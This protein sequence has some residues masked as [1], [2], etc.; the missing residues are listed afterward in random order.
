LYSLF[1]LLLRSYIFSSFYTLLVSTLFSL[2]I[3]QSFSV[4]NS[5]TGVFQTIKRN[6]MLLS[7]STENVAKIMQKLHRFH[8]I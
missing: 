2:S 1:I 5:E 7:W 3:V 8:I 4:R 6:H